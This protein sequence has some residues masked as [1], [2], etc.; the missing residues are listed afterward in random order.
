M[1]NKPTTKQILLGFRDSEKW[2][3]KKLH[4]DVLSKYD[5]IHFEYL[6]SQIE[7]YQTICVKELE[8]NFKKTIKEILEDDS[9]K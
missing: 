6:F 4:Y 8:K 3:E 2:I 5:R 9:I 1:E 7:E